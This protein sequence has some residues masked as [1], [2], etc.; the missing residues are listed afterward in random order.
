[1][2]VMGGAGRGRISRDISRFTILM[3]SISDASAE[4]RDCART[5]TL[6]DS[7]TRYLVFY[8]GATQ[9]AGAEDD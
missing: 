1:M 4:A 8:C 5:M 9:S 7:F 6:A 2:G 3:I